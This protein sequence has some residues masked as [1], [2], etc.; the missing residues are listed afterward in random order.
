MTRSLDARFEPDTPL[1]F[2]NGNHALIRM[3]VEQMRSDAAAGLRT[4]AFVTGYPG[5]PLGSIDIAMRQAR[6]TLDAHGITHQPAQNE[7]FAVSMLSGTQMLDEHPHPEVDGV[8]GYWYG[9]G[10]GLDRSGDALKHANF[11]GTSRHG[12]VV[13]LSGEDHE[14]KSSTVPYQQD[15]S[16]EHHG[17]P[18]LYPSCVQEF[19]DYGLHAAALSRYSGCWVA[20]KLVGTL[21]DGG[22]VVQLHPAGITTRT[23][24]LQIAGKPFAKLANH[25][26]FPVTNVETERRLY[27]ERHAAVL[28]Y[29]RANGLN[30][31]VR[32]SPGD[33]IGI[34]SAGKSWA[35]TLQALEDLGLDARALEANG[36]RLAKVGLLCPSDS[37][38]FRE[39]AEGLERVIVVEEKRDFLERQVAAGIVGT[40]V[41][42]LARQARRGRSAPLPRRRRHDQ[43]HGG[44]TPRARAGAQH[45]VAG[46]RPR[47]RAI[48]AAEDRAAQ[49]RAARACTELLLGLPP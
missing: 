34:V 13:I 43:R 35:D 41:R 32:S 27:D 46:A 8:V 12:A 4:K 25:R 39:F 18:V 37:A 47:A 15:F 3:M 31:V 21:C 40:S 16:F 23:P 7:E 49:P 6:R 14:A 17:M 29:S 30:R 26:F 33:R 42:E 5:S 10:P 19:L 44:R 2:L 1:A 48:P 36:I 24:D 20:L 9:K 11:A 22:E 38:F 45:H 28:A